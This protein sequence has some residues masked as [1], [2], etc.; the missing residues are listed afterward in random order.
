MRTLTLVSVAFLT[1]IAWA[2]DVEVPTFARPAVTVIPFEDE[3]PSTGAEVPPVPGMAFDPE[4]PMPWL[5][6]GLPGILELAFERSGALNV[7]PRTEFAFAL[8]KRRDVELAVDVPFTVLGDVAKR[9][10]ATHVVGGSF[11]KEGPALSFTVTVW[12]AGVETEGVS[13]DEAE[14]ERLHAEIQKLGEELAIILTDPARSAEEKETRAADVN[15]KIA[16]VS[17]RIA[18]IATAGVD[19]AALEEL[20]RLAAEL[21]VIMGDPELSWEEKQARAVEVEAA[22]E[23]TSARVTGPAAS[24]GQSKEFAGKVEDLFSLVDAATA[25]VLTATDAGGTVGW[26]SMAS[27]NAVVKWPEPFAWLFQIFRIPRLAESRSRR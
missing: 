11:V 15:T 3:S 8:D 1:A 13:P 21:G 24:T 10:G 20:G 6:D 5:S 12:E 25:F 4:A 19:A 18:G 26:T 16:E 7:V 27:P 2:A 23:K 22:M 17:A 9:E 14:L